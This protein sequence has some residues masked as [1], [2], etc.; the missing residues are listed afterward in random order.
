MS[1]AK[2]K[3][4]M[5]TNH[6]NCVSKDLAFKKNKEQQIKRSRIDRSDNAAIYSHHKA[7]RASCKVALRI[8][9]TKALHTYGETLVKPA[10]VDAMAREVCGDDVANKLAM[11]TLSRCTIKRRIN[12]LSD[13]I[14]TQT[15]GRIKESGKF[16]LQLDETTDVESNAQLMVFVRYRTEEDYEEQFLFCREV[17]VRATSEQVFNTVN[18]FFE[19]HNL[20]WINCVAVCADGAP[21]MMG[22]N[23]GVYELCFKGKPKAS[24]TALSFTSGEPCC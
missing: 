14:L 20:L 11:V 23:G 15:I 1:K 12:D 24:R 21:A 5:T 16:S 4:H 17:G 19:D 13:N 2:L 8:T 18:K 6:A 7:L 3:R 10:A 9:K 22:K